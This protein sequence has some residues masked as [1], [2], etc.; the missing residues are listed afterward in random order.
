MLSF[1]FRSLSR[2]VRVVCG[3][4]GIAL[5]GAIAIAIVIELGTCTRRMGGRL[6]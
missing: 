5:N 2:C 6:A 4:V 1:A 3:A